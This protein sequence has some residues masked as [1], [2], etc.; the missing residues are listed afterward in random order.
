M[1]KINTDERY[2]ILLRLEED[3][4][5]LPPSLLDDTI[6]IINEIVG[7]YHEPAIEEA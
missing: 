4:T 1:I 6:E 2:R 3:G 7:K 5:I